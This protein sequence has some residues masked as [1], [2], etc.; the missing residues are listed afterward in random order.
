MRK[1]RLASFNRQAG[2]F[3]AYQEL[4]FAS[5]RKW[6]DGMM[7]SWILASSSQTL[8]LE[9]NIGTVGLENQNESN[10]RNSGTLI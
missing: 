10:C 3:H 9:E 2:T 8:R 7:D 5:L 1:A 6:N 4:S